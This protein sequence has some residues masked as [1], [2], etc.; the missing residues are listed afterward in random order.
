MGEIL[1]NKFDHIQAFKSF[2]LFF[3]QDCTPIEWVTKSIPVFDDSGL[4]V[5]A[6]APFSTRHLQ[7]EKIIELLADWRSSNQYAY[8]TQFEVT[9]EGT[10]RWLESAVLNNTNRI[11]FLILN[12]SLMPVGHIGVLN[13]SEDGL[14]L[15]VD[16][17]L[18]GVKNSTPGLLSFS[19]HALEKW[20]ERELSIDNIYLRVLDSNEHAISFYKKLGYETVSTEE[21]VWQEKDRTRTLVPGS[22]PDDKLNTMGKILGLKKEIPEQIL[23]AGP[24]IG[25]YE[26]SYAFSAAAY[27]WNNNHS[28]FL[29]LFEQEFANYVGSEFAMATSSCT[30]ALHLA[31]L[32]SGIGPGDEVIVPEVSWVATASAV[33]YTG[34]KPI[35]A[36][37]DPISWTIDVF[38]AES[39]I[40]ENTKAILPVH[41]YGFPADMTNI[42]NLAIKYDLKLIED[43]APAIGATVEGQSVG[44]FGEFGC[45]SFQGA[46]MLVTGEGGML[47]TND[48]NLA[49]K[50]KKLQ[51]HGRKPGTFWIEELGYKYKMSNI[52]ASIGLAQLVRS[53]NQ[54]F[55][56]KRINEWYKENLSGI[57]ELTFQ[58]ELPGAESIDWMTS[59]S[60]KNWNASDREEFTNY[61]K[62]NGVDT[63]PVFP[64]MSQ[65]P[66]WGY[67][68][69]VQSNAEIIGYSGVNLPSG[70][71]LSRG[72][73]D[74][75]SKLIRKYLRG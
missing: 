19:M 63:R 17:V 47:V 28:D 51:E 4:E 15:E 65:F 67:K 53:D 1:A 69:P 20:I 13:T 56:K 58:T 18:R 24:L 16:N 70:V 46:K 7:D 39:L 38:S 31:L 55:R 30:G 22:P 29:N 11:L 10:S 37:I 74:K 25:S 57:S 8:P 36:D 72:E 41:L 68:P 75:V 59:I 61:L 52:Q 6:L 27:G 2:N 26:K 42:K 5:G 50:A 12:D 43:A 73:I 62:D 66:I 71:N 54:I 32:A 21:M 14:N 44:T 23:T 49:A 34:A 48:P 35:F 40:N 45:Y 64:P 33:M 3:K 9:L 60:N